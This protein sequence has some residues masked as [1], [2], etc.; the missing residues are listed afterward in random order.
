MN[1]LDT[2]FLAT[3]S[4]PN[5]YPLEKNGHGRNQGC[6]KQERVHANTLERYQTVTFPSAPHTPLFQAVGAS[7]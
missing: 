7:S 4:E 6:Y 1:F 3:S 2:E 5:R